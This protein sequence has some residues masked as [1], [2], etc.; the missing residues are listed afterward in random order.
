MEE[1][2]NVVRACESGMGDE[3]FL[4]KVPRIKEHYPINNCSEVHASLNIS[5]VRA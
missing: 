4:A 2:L 3:D 1:K 5:S